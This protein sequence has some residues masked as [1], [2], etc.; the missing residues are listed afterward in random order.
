MLKGMLGA[1]KREIRS[2]LPD[3]EWEKIAWLYDRIAL[4]LGV[5]PAKSYPR[6]MSSA[7]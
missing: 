3:K 1:L 5:P 4:R 6:A 7:D 2:P